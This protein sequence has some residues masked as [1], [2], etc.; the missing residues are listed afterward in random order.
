M[1]MYITRVRGDGVVTHKWHVGEPS[2]LIGS[3]IATVTEVQ[4]DGDELQM[5]RR[6]ATGLPEPVGASKVVHWFGDHAKFIVAN[7]VGF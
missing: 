2:S 1:A 5:I 7:L 4:A 6:C 3:L